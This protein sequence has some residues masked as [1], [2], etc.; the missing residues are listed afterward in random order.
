MNNIEKIILKNGINSILF[1]EEEYL[2]HNIQK[3]LVLKL[4]NLFEETY[5]TFCN[6][7]LIKENETKFSKEIEKLVTFLENYDS[8]IN[9]K[10]IFNNNSIKFLNENE[11]HSIKI[12]FDKLNTKNRQLL[13]KNLFESNNNF[14]QIME[15]YNKVKFLH[16]L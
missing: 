7:L 8:K 10:I 11:V 2:K 12:L 4:K 3:V 15:F 16:K 13:A 9:N 1:E 5:K 14:E 6:N